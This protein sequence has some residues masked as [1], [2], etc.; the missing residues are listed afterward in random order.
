MAA[1]RID[2]SATPPS[3]ARTAATAIGWLMYGEASVSF[4]RC[5]LCLSAANARALSRDAAS[6]LGSEVFEPCLG[7]CTLFTASGVEFPLP[8]FECLVSGTHLSSSN[9]LAMLGCMW[10][11]QSPPLVLENHEIM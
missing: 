5:R 8:L 7:F 9:A 2:S 4:R 3:I 1:S 11:L 10:N 6:F